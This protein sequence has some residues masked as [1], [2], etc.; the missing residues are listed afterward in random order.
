MGDPNEL[1]P[2]QTPTGSPDSTTT[3]EPA[4]L[5]QE[6][7][8][9]GPAPVE[10]EKVGAEKTEPSAWAAIS[11]ASELLDHEGVKPLY[12]ERLSTAREEGKKE[13]ASETH[14]RLQP[15]HDRQQDTL[16]GIDEKV[17]RFT[18]SWTRLSRA[19]DADGNPVI[20]KAALQDLLDDNREAFAALGGLHRNEGTFS[21]YAG[22]V[23]E[24]AKAMNSDTFG[25]DFQPRLERVYRG[26]TDS[27][28]FTD[29]VEAIA[30][31]AK[32]PVRDELKEAKAQVKRL[33]DEAVQVKR[34][35][36]APPVNPPGGAGGGG[37]SREEEDKTLMNPETPIG[38]IKEI[39][40]RRKG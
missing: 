22:L 20:D 40:A 19:K 6:K 31:E 33:E 17:G 34:N 4:P 9:D 37:T 13:G 26:D 11:D 16:R 23:K 1:S 14:K 39:M 10:G 12:D 25:A 21:G 2:G 30:D 29:M 28:I 36:Q 15:L 38:T 7:P 35:G 24:L 3:L 8:G 27:A 5:A 18:D 32:K